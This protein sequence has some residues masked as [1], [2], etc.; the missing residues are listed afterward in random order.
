MS[1]GYSVGDFVKLL[2]L[3]NELRHRFVDA[4]EQFQ[5]ISSE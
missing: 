3:A 5:A 2:E 1:F 4:P